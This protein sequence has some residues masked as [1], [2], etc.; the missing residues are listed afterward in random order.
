MRYFEKK[1]ISE[2]CKILG[3]KEGTVNSLLSRGL[4]KLKLLLQASA[5]KSVIEDEG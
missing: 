1:K 4:D 2:I 3:K 5:D